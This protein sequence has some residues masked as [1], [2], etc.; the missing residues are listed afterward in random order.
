MAASTLKAEFLR[1]AGSRGPDASPSGGPQHA[2][3]A[4]KIAAPPGR[5]PAPGQPKYNPNHLLGSGCALPGWAEGPARKP[6]DSCGIALLALRPVSAS[7]RLRCRSAGAFGHSEIATS[8]RFSRALAEILLEPFTMVLTISFSSS[9][10]RGI[11]IVARWDFSSFC[12]PQ[13]ERNPSLGGRATFP[14][15]G[16]CPQA[17]RVPRPVD[18][19][20]LRFAAAISTLLFTPFFVRVPGRFILFR[21][22][23]ERVESPPK[24]RRAEHFNRRPLGFHLDFARRK[25]SEIPLQAGGRLFLWERT[26]LRPGG[27]HVPWTGETAFRC[28]SLYPTL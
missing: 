28:G 1:P 8:T 13:N 14:M 22:V 12:S 15:G 24:T 16:N 11:S 26:A 10:A 5:R 9:R 3:H 19:R 2:A 4:S 6:G 7:L 20:N 27:P 25:T 18:G 17:G 21:L 23:A